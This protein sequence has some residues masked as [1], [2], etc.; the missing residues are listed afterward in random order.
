[1]IALRVILGS[2]WSEYKRNGTVHGI[3]L[4]A[5]L[6]ESQKLEQPLFTPS[7]KADQGLHDENITPDKGTLYSSIYTLA[8]M[9]AI[10]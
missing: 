6:I 2:A 8:L 7:T 10:L 9:V 5:G 4:P 3:R 1:M